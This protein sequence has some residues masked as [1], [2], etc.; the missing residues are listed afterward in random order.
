MDFKQTLYI[1]KILFLLQLLHS[2]LSYAVNTSSNSKLNKKADQTLTL[3]FILAEAIKSSDTFKNVMSKSYAIAQAEYLSRTPTD[4]HITSQVGRQF[5]ESF[6]Q[7]SSP[8]NPPLNDPMNMGFPQSKGYYYNLGA[9]A[10]FQTGT[11]TTLGFNNNDQFDAFQSELEFSVSQSLLKDSFGYQTK[12][13]RKAGQLSSQAVEES[14]ALDIENWALDIIDLYYNAWK[15]RSEVQT[16]QNHLSSKERLVNITR[17]RLRRGTAERSDLLQVEGSLL[18]AQIRLNSSREALMGIWRDLVHQLKLPKEY[19][20]YDPIQI[21]MSLDSAYELE[22][23]KLKDFPKTSTQIK[24]WEYL[25]DASL[26]KKESVKNA[27]LPDVQLK[28]GLSA[29][30]REDASAFNVMGRSLSFENTSGFIGLQFGMPL[31][32]FR[33]KADLS[34]VL[35]KYARSMAMLSILRTQIQVQWMNDCSRFK[36]LKDIVKLRYENLGKQ[37]QRASLDERRYRLGR[38]P[39]LQIIQSVDEATNSYLLW[40][41]SQVEL[42]LNAW[43]MLRASGRLREL[44]TKFQ[45]DIQQSTSQ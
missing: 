39:L 21:P 41:E 2:N 40:N 3:D 16:A 38:I 9:S 20:S 7:F 4:I 19:L 42:K 30:N 25:K 23:C 1:T 31:S 10:Y 6:P 26:L 37:R 35:A 44:L 15:V 8:G 13:L 24:Y 11:R 22:S 28:V 14:L 33:E 45:T 36:Q 43:R 27:F 32:K 17:V 18:E 5:G 29:A 34:E 12:R